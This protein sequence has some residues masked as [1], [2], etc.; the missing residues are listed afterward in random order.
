MNIVPDPTL[1]STYSIETKMLKLEPALYF[2]S[3]IGFILV[4]SPADRGNVVQG[5]G[6]PVSKP[7]VALMLVMLTSPP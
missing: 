1:S 6:D 2:V 4:I 3:V 7:V 5:I